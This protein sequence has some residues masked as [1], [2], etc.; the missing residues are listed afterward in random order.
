[1][2]NFKI[3]QLDEEKDLAEISAWDTEYKN[4]SKYDSIRQFILED[5]IFTSLAEVIEINHDKYPIGNYE[6]AYALCVKDCK[7][8]KILGFT[9]CSVIDL[10]TK[11]PELIIKYI[12]IHPDEQGKGLGKKVVSE[13][14]TNSSNLFDVQVQKVF[15]K[16][17]V[18]NRHS[19]KMFKSLGFDISFQSDSFYK[20]TKSYLI[21]EKE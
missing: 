18:R 13:L 14:I 6:R 15:A 12:V 1:M 11:E 10:N 3:T 16:I 20:A 5:Y 17:D 2:K 21:N 7:E 4:D 8:E 9:L 19:R